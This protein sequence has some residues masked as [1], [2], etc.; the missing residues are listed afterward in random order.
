MTTPTNAVT[1]REPKTLRDHL[2]SPA[3]MA[4]I[5]ESMP[6]HL[7]P[8]R[9]V[10]VALAAVTRIPKLMEVSQ[11]SMFAVFRQLS[12]LGLEPDGRRAHLIPFYNSKDKRMEVQ[13]II[14]YKGLVELIYRSG[15]VTKLHADVVCE[16]DIF[17]YNLGEIQRHVIDFKHKDGR[18]EVYAVYA[19]AV[20]K[21]GVTKCEVMSI[22]EIEAIRSRSK[23]G[24][25]GPWVSDWGEMAKKTVFRRLSKWL[26][27]SPDLRDAAET[28]DEEIVV[29]TNPPRQR[30]P[31]TLGEVQQIE[32]A[33]PA[34]TE[35]EQVEV[36]R[37]AKKIIE[38]N[39]LDLTD[40]QDRALDLDWWEGERVA[41]ATALS[42][43]A[44]Q[45]IVAN[46]A[47]LVETVKKISE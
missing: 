5:A 38:D 36:L 17:D 32:A 13:L 2:K 26:P 39:H 41:Y 37:A 23:S 42:I 19:L 44:C 40:L 11:E 34:T 46:A 21:S 18:G 31:V 27:L 47:V 35:A 28:D 29:N 3:F 8:E 12:S 15:E 10:S 9:F 20:M 16:N 33:V 30:G 25:S 24:L 7:K 14:D 22:R 45:F 1:T 43:P 6:R 4:S